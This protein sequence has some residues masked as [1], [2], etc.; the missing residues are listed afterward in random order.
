[1]TEPQVRAAFK[2]LADGGADTSGIDTQRALRRGRA[3]LRWRRVGLAGAPVLAAA[4]AAAVAVTVSVNPFQS[5]AASPAAAVGGPA[6]PRAFNPLVT[7]VAFGWLPAKD[8]LVSGGVYPA[9]AIAEASHWSVGV[10]A[11][12]RCHVTGS[13]LACRGAN[14]QFKLRFD[15]RAPSVHGH[16][17]FWAGADPNL[18]WEYARGGWAALGVPEGS[19]SELRQHKAIEAQALKIARNLQVGATTPLMFPARFTG[20]PSSWQVGSVSFYHP[21]G[22]VLLAQ[23]YLVSNPASAFDRHI[24]DLG[25][26]RNAPY[27][28]VE[29]APKGGTCSPNDPAYHHTNETINGFH[30]VVKT[31]TDQG[32]RRQ[33]LCGAHADGL[34]V[35]IQEFGAH[36]SINV[37]TLFGKNLHLLGANPANWTHQPLG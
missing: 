28:V 7:N 18:V 36:P 1:M 2:Q 3:R 13:G 25:V 33:E 22:G 15:A 4:V 32:M 26:W 5:G 20:L 12:G 6:A 11:R 9:E 34:Y 31:R 19:F 30:V 17:A 27:V 16:R 35:D 14:G 24:G 21:E 37:A 23:E 8:S 10:F 29:P